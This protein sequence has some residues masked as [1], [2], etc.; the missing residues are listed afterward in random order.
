MPVEMTVFWLF[1][2]RDELIVRF[3]MYPSRDQALAATAT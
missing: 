1:G 3:H 2:F